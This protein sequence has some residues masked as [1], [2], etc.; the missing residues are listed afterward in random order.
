MFGTTSKDSKAVGRQNI[1]GKEYY[2]DHL[3]RQVKR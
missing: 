1:D 2:F 3:G